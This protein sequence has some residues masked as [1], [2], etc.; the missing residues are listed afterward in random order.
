MSTTTIST[1]KF[2]VEVQRRLIDSF[3]LAALLGLRSRQAVWDRV[4]KGTLP[5]PIFVRDKAI[6]LWDL[7]A[8][9]LPD[10][11]EVS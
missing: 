2:K 10:R 3:E 9:D 8:L 1:E 7:D 11:K 5:E 4:R 6:W